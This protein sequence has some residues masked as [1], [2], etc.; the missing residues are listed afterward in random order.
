M[1]N[2]ELITCDYAGCD[3][4]FAYRVKGFNLC[5]KH[6]NLVSGPPIKP[7]I[8]QYADYYIEWDGMVES[9]PGCME[10]VQARID[11]LPDGHPSKVQLIPKE[12]D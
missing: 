8:G 4:P 9:G 12:S 7:V 3:K 2:N 6:C 1:S 10:R 5:I 11:A